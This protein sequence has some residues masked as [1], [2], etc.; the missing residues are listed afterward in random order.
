MRVC[1]LDT[2]PVGVATQNPV[3]RERFS[4]RPEFVVNFFEFIAQE[5]REHLASL[6]FRS[7]EE[8]VGHVDVAEGERGKVALKHLA[9][10]VADLVRQREP[11]PRRRLSRVHDYSP[12][13]WEEEPGTVDLA[14]LDVE[15]AVHRIARLGDDLARGIAPLLPGGAQRGDM[16]GRQRGARHQLEVAADRFRV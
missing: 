3:L 2:C 15:E 16:L 9:H 12:L 11:A 10:P 14:L 7:V 6:G 4:G 8:A 5:V 13:A 1:H